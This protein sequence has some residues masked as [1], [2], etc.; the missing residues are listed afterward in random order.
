MLAAP[1]I[2]GCPRQSII[3][4][5]L[6]KANNYD[7]LYRIK[8]SRGS[9]FQ[10]GNYR[11]RI[12]DWVSQ[13]AIYGKCMWDIFLAVAQTEIRI[14]SEFPIVDQS[15]LETIVSRSEVGVLWTTAA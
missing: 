10:I 11:W 1:V 14:A 4:S 7:Y 13:S 5:V 8:V 12:D 6:C 9:R 3:R 2:G 15:R